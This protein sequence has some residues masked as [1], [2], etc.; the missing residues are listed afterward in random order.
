MCGNSLLVTALCTTRTMFYSQTRLELSKQARTNVQP[1][2]ESWVGGNRDLH[3]FAVRTTAWVSLSQT[4]PNQHLIRHSR[5]SFLD[6]N[7]NHPQ[8]ISHR[9]MLQ[10]TRRSRRHSNAI[11]KAHSCPA[12]KAST[13]KFAVMLLVQHFPQSINRSI[14][15]ETEK[16]SYT[17]AHSSTSPKRSRDAC[18]LVRRNVLVARGGRR[19]A[20]HTFDPASTV[21]SRLGL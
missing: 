2:S 15:K 11:T 21:H 18:A 4:S 7:N 19:S 8:E 14:R 9:S 5:S 3:I 16:K 13:T 20:A 17:S 1:M 12:R 10:H 6:Q